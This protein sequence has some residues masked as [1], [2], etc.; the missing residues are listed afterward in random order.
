MTYGWAILIIAVI[1]GA[2]FSLGF[3]NSASLA[4]KVP[5][6]SCTV[7][8]PYGPGTSAYATLQGTCNNQL[9]E[10]VAKF[11]G[12]P[13]QF[14]NTS[15]L[16]GFSGGTQITVTAWV[17][18][19]NTNLGYINGITYIGSQPS[20][21]GGSES[22]TIATNLALD[23][24]DSGF[25]SSLKG[26]R[27]SWNFVAYTLNGN[28]ATLYM[29]GMSSNG[30]LVGSGPIPLA[31]PFFAI[32]N[33]RE[34]V[35]RNSINGSIADVQVYNISLSSSAIDFLYHEGIGGVPVDLTHLVGWWPLNGN[36]NDYSG[37]Q[38]NGVNSNVIYT[39]GW[40]SSYSA[41]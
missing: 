38:D 41:P 27:Y 26:T 25:Y 39:N 7:E 12:K 21:C 11:D 16:I 19:N 30:P 36:A 15:P 28:I 6:G 32:G 9:P 8:R 40:T 17:Y 22:L 23:T 35:L 14:V 5:P 24:C 13:D 33:D 20:V 3:F 31:T 10:F 37:N 34:Y 4:P 1:L 18:L 2:L 29:N